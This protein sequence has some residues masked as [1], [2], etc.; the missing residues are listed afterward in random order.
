MA[1]VT[2]KALKSGPYEISGEAK[3]LDHAGKEYAE[4]AID[5]IYLCRCGHSK[6]KPFCDGSH[7]DIGFKAEETAK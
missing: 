1:D 4:S 6:N 3:I 2:V 7:K 5:P